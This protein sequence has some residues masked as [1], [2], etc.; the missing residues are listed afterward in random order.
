MWLSPLMQIL[1]NLFCFPFP[2][3]RSVL[4]NAEGFVCTLHL[5]HLSL[6]NH[7]MLTYYTAAADA[8][9]L[10][11]SFHDD[12]SSSFI[13]NS[14]NQLFRLRVPFAFPLSQ[15]SDS[16]FILMIQVSLYLTLTSITSPKQEVDRIQVLPQAKT[17][18]LIGSM[19]MFFIFRC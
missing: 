14:L 5:T 4:L 1:C 10:Y 7:E 18:E 12:F 17:D 8:A 15:T 9:A 13:C 6:G 11:S 19:Y 2:L 16:I 3:S